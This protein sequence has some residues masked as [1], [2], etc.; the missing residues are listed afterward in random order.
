MKPS[1]VIADLF[2]QKG[3]SEYGGESVTQLEHALQCAAL[4]VECGASESLVVAALLHDIGHL[5]HDLPDDAPEIG[6]DDR[7]E[8][9]G[10]N[11]LKKYFGDDVCEPVHLHVDAKRYL[12]AVD[13]D[14]FSRLSRPSVVSLELQGGPMSEQ[15]VAEFE[16]HT[17][18][19]EAVQLR[20]WDDEGKIQGLD[21]PSIDAYLPM[22]D[23]VARTSVA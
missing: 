3:G 7:H 14:Y 18:Y 4:A 20:T 23:R 19:R 2:E 8:V 15:E 22:I 21:V 9:S 12:C 11:F 1:R 5:L 16:R 13:G 6:I 10:Q 17:F